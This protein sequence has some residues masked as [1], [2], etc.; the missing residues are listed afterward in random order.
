M[1]TAIVRASDSIFT[2][3]LVE[4]ELCCQSIIYFPTAQPYQWIVMSSSYHHYCY[5]CHSPNS[6]KRHCSICWT[7]PDLLSWTSQVEWFHPIPFFFWTSLSESETHCPLR[8]LPGYLQTWRLHFGVRPTIL[9]TVTSS[10]RSEE[11]SCYFRW[12][13]LSRT[14]LNKMVERPQAFWPKNPLLADFHELFCF[15]ILYLK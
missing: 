7:R 3:G 5:C 9:H 2:A 8:E 11:S 15:L 12:D 13:I 10:S 6:R 4:L 1:T 14:F